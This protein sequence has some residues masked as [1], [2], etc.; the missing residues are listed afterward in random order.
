[1]VLSTAFVVVES[2]QESQWLRKFG[3]GPPRTTGASESVKDVRFR[4]R[5]IRNFLSFRIR[6]AQPSSLK[7]P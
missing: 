7:Q 3:S 2:Q 4:G 1:M 6:C 5:L